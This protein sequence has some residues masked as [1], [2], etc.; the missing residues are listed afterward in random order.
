META[1]VV[2]KSRISRPYYKYEKLLCKN[3]KRKVAFWHTFL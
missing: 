1:V 3:K 2:T